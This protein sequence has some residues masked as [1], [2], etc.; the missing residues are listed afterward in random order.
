[1]ILN[2]YELIEDISPKEVVKRLDKVIMQELFRN[3][4]KLDNRIILDDSTLIAIILPIPGRIAV[5]KYFS[6]KH[7]QKKVM[8]AIDAIAE[9]TGNEITL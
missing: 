6:D 7:T 4:Q 1:M 2:V 9:P 3:V 5:P 8:Q